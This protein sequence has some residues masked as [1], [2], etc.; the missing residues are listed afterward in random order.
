MYNTAINSTRHK[1]DPKE[2]LIEFSPL[3]SLSFTQPQM[4]VKGL[5][6]LLR[7]SLDLE[8]DLQVTRT[9]H[10]RLNEEL[11]VLREL[12]EQLESARQ[13]GQHV[14]PTWVQE[15]ERFRLLLKHTERQVSP[16]RFPELTNPQM[17][18]HRVLL[19]KIPASDFVLPL[20]L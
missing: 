2:S 12:K 6:G 7:T 19:N 1:H 8:L 17:A 13:Q 14:L 10:S 11:R 16:T 9:R 3:C 15:D 20:S 18:C 5:D 4:Q